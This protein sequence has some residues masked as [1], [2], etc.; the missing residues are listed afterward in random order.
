MLKKF[1]ACIVVVFMLCAS[2]S[3][4]LGYTGALNADL[5]SARTIQ[6]YKYQISSLSTDWNDY[7]VTEKV[8]ML[9][10]PADTLNKM[11]D[12]A[13]VNAIAEYPYLIDIYVY[14]DSVTDGIEISRKY[15]SALDEL[16]SRKS[17]SEALSNYGL[18]TANE[19]F[20]SY[21]LASSNKDSHNLFVGT[22]MLDIVEY[23]NDDLS[24][25]YTEVPSASGSYILSENV[26]ITSSVSFFEPVETHTVEQ[27]EAA[28]AEVLRAY[29]VT[30]ISVGTCKY[31]CHSYA[32]YNRSPMNTVWIDDPTPFMNNGMYTRKF[33][34]SVSSSANSTSVRY[35]DIIFYGN[36]NGNPET[37][38]SAVYYS[39][40]NSGAPL[41]THRCVSKW[42]QLGVFEHALAVV[43]A[44]Y[45]TSLISAWREV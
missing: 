33:L 30:R 41:A 42:G 43:P 31:N 23:V 9:R 32:W 15:F 25:K 38:H 44:A 11:T 26:G 21:N 14:G 16:L 17:A 6:E 36:V 4:A 40:M 5:A 37:W 2:A 45:D 24:V 27:H 13:L 39:Q 19:Y 28:D 7:S 1:T 34:G 10:I 35:G 20:S 8:E 29:A 12:E 22:A 18:K 3:G